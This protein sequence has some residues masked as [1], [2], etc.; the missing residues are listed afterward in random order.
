MYY[1]LNKDVDM[2][3]VN[4]LDSISKLVYLY[5]LFTADENGC[6]AEKDLTSDK[7]NNNKEFKEWVAS[8]DL[9]RN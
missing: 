5:I 1:K 9:R 8:L 4:S 3:V 2:D 7:M 6:V